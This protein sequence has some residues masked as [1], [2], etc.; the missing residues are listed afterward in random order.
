[1]APT[2]QLIRRAASLRR[3]QHRAAYAV[4]LGRRVHRG[5]CGEYT[6]GLQ[7]LRSRTGPVWESWRVKTGSPPPTKNLL[8]GTDGLPPPPYPATAA[9]AAAKG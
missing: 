9:A 8:E 1:M 6:P 3:H 2:L 5:L 7:Q 4:R